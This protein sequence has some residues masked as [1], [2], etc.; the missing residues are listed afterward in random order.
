MKLTH[1]ADKMSADGRVSPLCAPTPRAIDL[2]RATWT[3]I[4]DAVTCPKCLKIMAHPNYMPKRN[5]KPATPKP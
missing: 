4:S 3:I 2:N 1:L 5:I